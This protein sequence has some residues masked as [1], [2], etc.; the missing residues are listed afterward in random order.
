MFSQEDGH[1]TTI[2]AILF[3]PGALVPHAAYAEVAGRLSDQGLVVVVTSMEPFRLAYHHLGSDAISMKRIMRR[4]QQQVTASLSTT[5]AAATTTTGKSSKSLQWTILGHSMGCFSAMRLFR[6][7]RHQQQQQQQQRKAG[8]SVPVPVTNKLVLWGV[9]AFL[10]FAVDLSGHSDAR[11]LVVQ[12]TDD[13]LVESLKGGQDALEACFPA[14]TTEKVMIVGG[15]HDGF[16]SYL[17]ANARKTDDT[18]AY[19]GLPR[20]DQHDQTCS[21]TVRFLLGTDQ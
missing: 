11:V 18:H 20:E 7:L 9:A 4:V 6:D 13:Q 19:D 2:P 10:P 5:A 14:Q 21:A 8:W 17:P 16:A 1:T 3:L 15:T 12:G